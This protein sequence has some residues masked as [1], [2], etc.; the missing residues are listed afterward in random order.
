MNNFYK[1]YGALVLGL[2][3]CAPFAESM[4]AELAPNAAGQTSQQ[5][6]NVKCENTTLTQGQFLDM[7]HAITAHGDLI[8]V[9]FIE[10]TLQVKLKLQSNVGA[11]LRDANTDSRQYSSD[12]L[13]SHIG[14][15]MA[16]SFNP[17]EYEKGKEPVHD[18]EGYINIWTLYKT[19]SNF[20][21]C[22][23][24]KNEQLKQ[25]FGNDF[26]EHAAASN[27]PSP[28]QG[29]ITACKNL[30]AVDGYLPIHFVYR[31]RKDSGD[32][33]EILLSQFKPTVNNP[34]TCS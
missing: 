5:Q 14:I 9:P 22:G 6:A 4:A 33:E 1:Y 10:K 3:L 26:V 25:V 11:A 27:P 13:D 20:K 34:S 12:V 32:I 15:Y 18:R 19:I 21:D 17:A 2:M 28:L 29:T 30:S 16:V 31:Y 7:L 8:D 23:S 24:L